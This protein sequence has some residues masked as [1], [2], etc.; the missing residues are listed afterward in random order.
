MLTIDN[1]VHVVFPKASGEHVVHGDSVVLTTASDVH[2]VQGDD[3]V[4]VP[5]DQRLSVERSFS[6]LLPQLQPA[7]TTATHKLYTL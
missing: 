2:V 7:E 3:V 1:E 5:A 6:P 4:S